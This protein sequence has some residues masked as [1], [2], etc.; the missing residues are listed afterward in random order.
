MT[1]A[2]HTEALA[3][4][5]HALSDPTRTRI[6][7]L[8]NAGPS[9]PAEMAERIGVSRQTLSNHL[10]CLRGCGLVVAVPEGRRTRYELADPRIGHAL[11]DLMGLVLAVDPDC[12]CI[13]PGGTVCECV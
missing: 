12:R 6:L 13:G 7:L 4:F 3:R 9:Y 2:T 11:D 10:A 1:P 5:G 8:L